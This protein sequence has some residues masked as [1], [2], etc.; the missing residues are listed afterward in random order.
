M[1][2]GGY[3]SRWMMYWRVLA[4]DLCIRDREM[5]RGWGGVL[6][7][8]AEPTDERFV[9]RRRRGDVARRFQYIA[10][11]WWCWG[12]EGADEKGKS[13]QLVESNLGVSHPLMCTRYQHLN[14]FCFRVDCNRRRWEALLKSRA[15]EALLQGKG[16][17]GQ[18]CHFERRSQTHA[19]YKQLCLLARREKAKCT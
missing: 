19:T 8:V 2:G 9:F 3:S 13:L 11:G 7:I 18:R 5:R 15:L 14:I 10:V 17:K 1:G 4:V 12:G 16:A 6:C